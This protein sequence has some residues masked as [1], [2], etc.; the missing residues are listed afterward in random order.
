MNQPMAEILL[1]A[2]AHPERPGFF[3]TCMGRPETGSARLNAIP[4]W[5]WNPQPPVALP[6]G[7]PPCGTQSMALDFGCPPLYASDGR[8][9]CEPIIHDPAQ[10]KDLPVP[11]VTQGRIGAQADYL[12]RV[13]NLLP[14]GYVHQLWAP[15]APLSIAE[16]M[17]DNSFYTALIEHSDAVHELLEKITQYLIAGNRLLHQALGR[18]RV[19]PTACP[20][21]WCRAAGYYISDDTMCLLSPAMHR[22]YSVPYINRI[23]A[24]TGP[25]HYHSCTWRRQ[26]FDNLHDLENVIVFNWNPGNS[27]DP[28]IIM[29]EFAGQAVLAPHI[30]HRMHRDG[31][32]LKWKPDFADE[33]EFFKYFLDNRPDNGTVFIWFSNIV[34]NGPVMDR[35]YD[36]LHAEGLTPQARGVA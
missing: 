1:D 20:P 31:D 8:E 19:N 11:D 28:A 33:Y 22:E 36:L 24:A 25:V 34:E 18:E 5:D 27:E 12:R 10:V 4:Y 14:E 2:F 23:T 7:A 15:L 26:Y 16:L 32:V 29:R 35:I 3:Y 13:R 9:W 21:L 6:E 30:V 17:W